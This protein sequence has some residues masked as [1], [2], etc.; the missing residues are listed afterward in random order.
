[1]VCNT[2]NQDKPLNQFQ[3]VKHT[4]KPRNGVPYQ[5]YYYLKRCKE[6]RNRRNWQKGTIPRHEYLSARRQKW[7]YVCEI[8]V[9]NPNWPLAQIGAKFGLNAG[10]VSK[11][12]SEYMGDGSP[13]YM[14]I[15][16]ED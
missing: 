14:R 10:Q 2:C 15:R 11:I 13:V 1:M 6:C 12:I 9:N 16:S 4:F 5:D 7:G 3:R 8:Y